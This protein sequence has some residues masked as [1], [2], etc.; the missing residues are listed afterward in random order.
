MDLYIH[1]GENMLKLKID[2]LQYSLSNTK[3]KQMYI[4]Q[5][6]FPYTPL[7]ISDFIK[8]I[9]LKNIHQVMNGLKKKSKLIDI[10]TILCRIS[11]RNAQVSIYCVAWLIGPC[12][13]LNL[14]ECKL[15]RFL[16][17]TL[18]KLSFRNHRILKVKK[19]L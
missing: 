8:F 17:L 1:K 15:D 3:I 11:K 2:Y 13:Q 9:L 7:Y 5:K 10:W 16:M 12:E 4:L 18:I 14:I 6:K 19:R